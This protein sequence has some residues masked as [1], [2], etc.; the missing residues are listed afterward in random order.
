MKT[1]FPV[2]HLSATGLTPK[3]LGGGFQTHSLRLLD[4]QKK[5]W[6][7]RSIQ[8]F[9][10]AASTSAARCSRR[11]SD[12]RRPR[13]PR[14]SSRRPAGR[15]VRSPGR[16]SRAVEA[17]R[18]RDG[19][20]HSHDGAKRRRLAGA[21]AA[22]QADQLAGGRPR[23]RCRAG[24]GWSRCRRSSRSS[25]STAR[26]PSLRALAGGRLPITEAISSGSAKN[27][28]GRHVGE[29]L[30]PLQRDDPVAIL[31]DEVHVVLDQDD[32]LRRPRARPRRSASS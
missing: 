26:H 18:S 22:H 15:S 1:T 29:H 27:G 11:R 20:D 12:R 31:G 4:E 25:S 10:R 6:V 17:D 2:L 19:P 13:S 21:V 7:F 8:N 32:G 23:A 28:V 9:R 3:E 5:E 16:R 30:A 14:A 24:C